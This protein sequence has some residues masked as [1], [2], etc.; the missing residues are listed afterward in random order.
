MEKIEKLRNSLETIAANHAPACLACSFGV[1]DMVLIDMISRHNIAISVFT[2]DTGRLPDETYSLMQETKSRY[3]IEISV[4]FPE[5]KAVEAYSEQNGPNAF[6]DSVDLRK[7]CCQ[8]RKVEPLKRALQ[9]K[10]AWITGLRSQQSPTRVDMRDAE[11]D[12]HNGLHKFNPLLAWSE[13][14][15]WNYVRMQNVP[16]NALHDKG[17]PSI[18]CAPCTRAVAKGEDIRAGR[19]WWEDVS[20]KE[21]GLHRKKA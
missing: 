12:E 20:S 9:H 2:L 4:Y 18:G 19:W 16:Y 13:K 3:G 14:E 11:Y 7:S 8:I 1:E 15:I 17:F 5:S 21:C 10:R 6:Y